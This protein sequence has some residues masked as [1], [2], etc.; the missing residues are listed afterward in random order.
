M[1]LSLLLDTGIP[2]FTV[3][4]N[5]VEDTGN[6]SSGLISLHAQDK[7]SRRQWQLQGKDIPVVE[8]YRRLGIDLNTSL[9]A[10]G[11]ILQLQIQRYGQ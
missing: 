3:I 6:R 2:I 10:K 1:G 11:F 5:T 7:V 9:S 8:K 4:C